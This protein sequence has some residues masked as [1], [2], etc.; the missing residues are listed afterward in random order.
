[1]GL[2]WDLELISYLSST[3]RKNR[4]RSARKLLVFITVLLLCCVCFFFFKSVRGLEFVLMQATQQPVLCQQINESYRERAL[5]QGSSC[6]LSLPIPQMSDPVCV[7][8][9]V[10][11]TGISALIPGEQGYLPINCMPNFL[12][13]PFC[14]L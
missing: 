4:S 9:V 14:T 5:Y 11:R 7:H 1:M 12:P 2:L 3:L 8:K 10:P 6:K 13:R